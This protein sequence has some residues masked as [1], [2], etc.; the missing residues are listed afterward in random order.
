[1]YDLV[2]QSGTLERMRTAGYDVILVSFANG[3]DVIQN[4]AQWSLPA[5]SR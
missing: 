4:N 3:T 1:L 5:W 2:N